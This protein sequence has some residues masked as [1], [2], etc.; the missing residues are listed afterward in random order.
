MND[1]LSTREKLA[2][3]ATN[4]EESLSLFASISINEKHQIFPMSHIENKI[5]ETRKVIDHLRA[6]EKKQASIDEAENALKE[7]EKDCPH[8]KNY[9]I[10]CKTGGK[11]DDCCNEDE[12]YGL[13][14]YNGKT[15]CCYAIIYI[16]NRCPLGRKHP[17]E[18]DNGM[19]T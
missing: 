4:Y 5:W 12:C 3:I 13:C 17:K 8:N 7:V 15:G 14:K 6:Y 16:A 10:D 19:P 9:C 2:I 1:E 18:L 11:P